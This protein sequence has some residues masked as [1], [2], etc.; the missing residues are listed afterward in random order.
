MVG[1]GESLKVFEQE[2]KIRDIILG[3][4]MWQ[5]SV[6]VRSVGGGAWEIGRHP[7]SSI[8]PGRLPKVIPHVWGP[9]SLPLSMAVFLCGLAHSFPPGN[10]FGL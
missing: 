2:N 1:N 10:H 6:G 4:F 8:T 3:S 7:C 5:H 9:W